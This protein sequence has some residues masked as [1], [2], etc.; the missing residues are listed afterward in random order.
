MAINI[1]KMQEKYSDIYYNFMPETYVL[2]E[3]FNLFENA[4]YRKQ[5]NLAR[6]DFHI[7]Q[8]NVNLWIVKPSGSS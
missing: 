6:S 2:P 5:G 3:E 8:S 7:R 1:K 4:F